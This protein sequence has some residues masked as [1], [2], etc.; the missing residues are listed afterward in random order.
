[1]GLAVALNMFKPGGINIILIRLMSMQGKLSFDR[2]KG[3]RIILSLSYFF[4]LIP[5]PAVFIWILDK[6]RISPFLL[7]AFLIQRIKNGSQF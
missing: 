4:A 1:M 5:H 3:G 7:S 2:R 6:E